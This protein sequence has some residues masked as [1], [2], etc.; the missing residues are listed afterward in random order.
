M[1]S[2][3]R[4]RLNEYHKV[5]AKRFSKEGTIQL[6]DGPEVKGATTGHLSSLNLKTDLYLGYIPDMTPV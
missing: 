2:A 6:D 3:D 1:R 4:I 5:V